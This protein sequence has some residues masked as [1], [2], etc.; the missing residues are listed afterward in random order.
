MASLTSE[1]ARVAD[2]AIAAV[3]S[4]VARGREAIDS[5][6]VVL[7][8]LTDSES[9]RA[10]RKESLR[11]SE[12]ILADLRVRR[13]SLDPNGLVGFVSLASAGA[14]VSA[15]IESAK[16]MT[17]AGF[18]REVVDPTARDLNPFNLNGKVGKA[19]LIGVVALVAFHFLT[20]SK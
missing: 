19:I 18:K 7:T 20:R 2:E 17:A 4:A 8:W 9:A 13:V 10:A 6:S 1:Q 14:E 12:K 3:E 16:R 5:E 15:L 11:Q